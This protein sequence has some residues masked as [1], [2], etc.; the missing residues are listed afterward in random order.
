MCLHYAILASSVVMTD[1]SGAVQMV[2]TKHYCSWGKGKG[3]K[4][5]PVTWIS[6]AFLHAWGEMG[7]TSCAVVM[8]WLLGLGAPA[9]PCEGSAKGLPFGTLGFPGFSEQGAGAGCT[10]PTILPAR[11]MLSMGMNVGAEPF[12][13]LVHTCF[14][15]QQRTCISPP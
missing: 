4:A 9:G 14:P 10:N 11:H 13:V 12:S 2:E 15:C 6:T 3:R 5:G 8:G 1:I 7:L